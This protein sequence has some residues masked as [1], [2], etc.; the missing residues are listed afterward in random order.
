M[1]RLQIDAHRETEG[2]TPLLFFFFS[3][4]YEWWLVVRIEK[5]EK[6]D[7]DEEQKWDCRSRLLVFMW[8]DDDQRETRECVGEKKIFVDEPEK[9]TRGKG[10]ER[11][12]KKA[13]DFGMVML[14]E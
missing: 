7:D 13:A 11:E 10:R 6:N 1:R 2:E 8:L 5:G 4:T 14:V 12:R 9:R 3:I